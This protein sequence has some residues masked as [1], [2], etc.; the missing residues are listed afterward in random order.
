[1]Q[2]IGHFP[3]PCLKILSAAGVPRT[4]ADFE[5]LHKQ[6]SLQFAGYIIPPLPETIGAGGLTPLPEV[7]AVAKTEKEEA[8]GGGTDGYLL[9]MIGGPDYVETRR[10]LLRKQIFTSLVTVLSQASS[11]NRTL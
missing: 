1:M 8:G 6:L 9:S 4:Y 5:W 7:L 10:K 3:A 11:I 2:F